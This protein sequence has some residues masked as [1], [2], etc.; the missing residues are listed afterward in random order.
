MI[1]FESIWLRHPRV[2]WTIGAF[3]LFGS[4]TTWLLNRDVPTIIGVQ[5]MVP[6]VEAGQPVKMVM[7]AHRTIERKCSVDISRTFVNSEHGRSVVTANQH[8]SAE[9]LEA[10]E[11]ETPGQLLITVNVPTNAPPGPSSFDTENRYK[12][13]FNPSTWVW[14]IEDRWTFN[15]NVAAKGALQ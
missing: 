4:V 11:R 15:V 8:V 6:T 2:W 13:P 7:P 5:Y 14:P 9:G 10:R 12:C 1:D 3:M